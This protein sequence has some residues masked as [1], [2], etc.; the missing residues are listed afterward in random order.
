MNTLSITIKQD[1]ESRSILRF[2][3]TNA[4]CFGMKMHWSAAFASGDNI[5][6]LA[7]ALENSLSE[8]GCFNR[9]HD[10]SG[11]ALE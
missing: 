8:N 7:Q 6:A 5:K 2:S 1:I 10:G 4:T 11:I 3:E 9:A